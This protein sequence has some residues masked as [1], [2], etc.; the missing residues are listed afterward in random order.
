LETVW[1][2]RSASLVDVLLTAKGS[3][4]FPANDTFFSQKDGNL[5]RQFLIFYKGHIL[6]FLIFWF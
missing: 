1:R 2:S 5:R 6:K 3:S 4:F